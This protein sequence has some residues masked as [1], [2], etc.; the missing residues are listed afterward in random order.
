MI[1][2]LKI[3]TSSCFVNQF[4]GLNINYNLFKDLKIGQLK[5]DKRARV[6]FFLSFPRLCKRQSSGKGSFLKRAHYFVTNILSFNF[7]CKEKVS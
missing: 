7:V 1:K 5:K 6:F 2:T 4:P 3:K